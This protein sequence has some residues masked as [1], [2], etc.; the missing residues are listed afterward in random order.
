MQLNVMVVFLFYVHITH[1]HFSLSSLY[2]VKPSEFSRW[3]FSLE[4]MK[5][6]YLRMIC[7][8]KVLHTVQMK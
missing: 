4:Q 3:I 8:K 5:K 1:E 6:E 7:M 2:G